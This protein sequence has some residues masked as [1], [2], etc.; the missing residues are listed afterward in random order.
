MKRISIFTSIIGAACLI[1]GGA[2]AQSAGSFAG[3]SDDGQFISLTVTQSGGTFT[4]TNM[5]VN[6]QAPCKRTG[7][8]ANEG[9]GFFLGDDISGGSTDFTSHNDYYYYTGSM[10]FTGP[11]TIK[12]TI[13]SYTATFVPGVTPPKQAQFCVSPKQPFTLTKQ[14]PG[15]ALPL[16][17]TV[18]AGQTNVD[19]GRLKPVR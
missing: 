2:S 1:G 7:D 8:T 19:T 14:A 11:H 9:W 12:G 5:D 15:K 10:H 13:T 18:A 3:T 6:I 16:P 17:A 4:V